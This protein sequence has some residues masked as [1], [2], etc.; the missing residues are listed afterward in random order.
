MAVYYVQ[1]DGGHFG[2][3]TR[4]ELQ[5]YIE[6][7]V[8]SE[9]DWALEE[10]KDAWV[11]LST[12]AK[13]SAESSSADPVGPVPD[14]TVPEPSGRGMAL[15]GIALLV[16]AG[17]A[18]AA[19]QFWGPRSVPKTGAPSK[20]SLKAS[21]FQP[22]DLP[23]APPPLRLDPL[24]TNN[25]P[26]AVPEELIFIP[27][28]DLSGLRTRAEAGNVQ[29]QLELARRH[30]MGRGVRWDPVAAF[31]W[32]ERAAAQDEPRARVLLAYFCIIR[33][34]TPVLDAERAA[35]MEEL[36][37]ENGAMAVVQSMANQGDAVALTIL[38]LGNKPRRGFVGNPEL[39]YR[40]FRLAADQGDPQAQH[41]VG[42]MEAKGVGCT[43]NV[44][45]GARW[46]AAAAGQ[47][48]ALSIS[49]LGRMRLQQVG[50]PENPGEGVRLIRQAAEL[51]V[52]IARH[53]LGFMYLKGNHVE[54]DPQQA[55]IWLLLAHVAISDARPLLQTLRNEMDPADY[56][57]A[58]AE[59]A[60]LDATFTDPGLPPPDPNS[61]PVPPTI[62][63][64][65]QS[66]VAIARPPLSDGSPA[67]A[68]QAITKGM[69]KGRFAE[70]WDALPV[71]YQT[72]AKAVL[73][74]AGQHLP[75]ADHRRAFALLGRVAKLMRE[76]KTELQ[77]LAPEDFRPHWDATAAML[78][79]LATSELADPGWYQNPDVPKL[80]Q[81]TGAKLGAEFLKLKLLLPGQGEEVW[82]A[83]VSEEGD[84]AVVEMHRG[85]VSSKF[86]LRRVEGKWLP[87]GLVAQWD[88]A[89]ATAKKSLGQPG[90]PND[91]R[92]ALLRHL[93]VVEDG[94]DQL[95]A[96]ENADQLVSRAKGLLK[97][98]HPSEP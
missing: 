20:E 3:L 21:V 7:G 24:P 15:A 50:L 9:D 88:E 33:F 30:E 35:R 41:W 95:D 18:F 53:R 94:L 8:L 5:R 12:Y 77:E 67:A 6:A 2:P 32:A 56:D 11:P 75:A 47:A 81:G 40:Q 62:G 68:M 36:G 27:L 76:K 58:L 54:T 14:A 72:D 66:G 80:L 19:W 71:S 93:G 91:N 22:G 39:A 73:Q 85:E 44:A 49:V 87:D 64:P 78:A 52:P 17:G 98:L 90:A 25:L 97:A 26:A 31:K 96:S 42:L 60:R 51:G 4:D 57:R 59:A 74:V 82:F 65:T 84:E 43:R 83:P 13:G 61:P 79:I 86:S 45:R 10:G 48:Q 16:V 70:L 23:K 29:A 55:C 46:I 63:K 34:G 37:R 38:G 28:K 69:E 89:I 92:D 1:K